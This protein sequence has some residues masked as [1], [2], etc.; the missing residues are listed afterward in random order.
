[1][2]I[3]QVGG[4]VRDQLLGLEPKDR[5]FVVVG[6]SEAEMLALGYE[7]VG[8]SFPVFLKNGE[9]YALART[10]RKTG[11]GYNGF[12]VTFDPTVTLEDDLIRRDLT[13]NA[14]AI[15]P[16]TGAIIDPYRGQIDLLHGVL[17][18]T[19]EA[20]AEDP[21]RVLRTARFA[22]RYGF[23]VAP[24]TLDLMGRIVGELEHVP[25]ERIWAEFEKG[26]MEDHPHRMFQVLD[27]CGAFKVECMLPYSSFNLEV[28]RR[29]RPS[30]SLAERFALVSG[31]FRDSDFETH[32]IP[33]HE[34]RVAAA[35][36]THFDTLLCYDHVSLERR[37]ALF[38]GTR[39]LSDPRVLVACV[40]AMWL[41]VP[42]VPYL[43][44]S[45]D[46]IKED[47]FRL[48]AVD[49]AAIAAQYKSGA[50]IKQAIE[51]ARLAVLQRASVGNP[52]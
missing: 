18:A 48:S 30:H 42:D 41:Y 33:T 2:K 22:A 8:A 38:T 51:Q 23:A 14:M 7:R 3:Y 36:R 13:I 31:H 35:Y 44:E 47:H 52:V 43:D 37:L 25:K 27:W 19:S 50:D 16:G 29:V 40:A 17:R 21:V 34:A 24:D 39:A 49:C 20:F 15:D 9:E 45:L 10:E 26:L 5:D 11:V 28:L 12:E 4:S 1:V 46:R 6:A 32:R